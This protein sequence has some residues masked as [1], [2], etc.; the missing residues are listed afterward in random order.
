MRHHLNILQ[1]QGL[2]RVIGSRAALPSAASSEAQRRTTGRGRPARVFGPVDPAPIANLAGLVAALLDEILPSLSIDEHDAFLARVAARLA[3]GLFETR[4][5]Q[6]PPL[7]ERVPPQSVF[8]ERATRPRPDSLTVRLF[9]AVERLN[10]AHYQARWEA[11][12]DAPRI[13]LGHCPFGDL[14]LH[15]P[16][17]CR[18]DTHLLEI[19]S[20]APVEQ[21]KR[22]EKDAR[23]LPYCLFR[24]T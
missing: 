2:V 19:L 3:A 1:Q 9:S 13:I 17:I 11:R 10:R 18:L 4:D 14:P 5:A 22:L 20:G 16:E 24:L 15:H 23:G 7:R 8:L 6:P 21:I 12:P